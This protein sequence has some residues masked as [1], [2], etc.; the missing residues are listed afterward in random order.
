MGL[1]RLF[2]IPE[3]AE[4]KDGAFV[5]TPAEEIYAILSV[6]SHRNSAWLVG[7]DLGTVPPE[8]DEA[9]KRHNVRG[10]YVA[11]TRPSPTPITRSARSPNR[12]SP[13]STPTTCPLS[14]PSGK[15]STSSIAENSTSS[16]TADSPSNRSYETSSDGP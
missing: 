9:M 10:M 5:S 16:T 14:G 7:E 4:A 13:A 15:G 11:S 12:P 1:H 6:E 8:V 3:G 2:W